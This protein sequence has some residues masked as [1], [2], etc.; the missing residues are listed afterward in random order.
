[1]KILYLHLLWFLISVNSLHAN[2][3][4]NEIKNDM[5]HEIIDVRNKYLSIKN[6]LLS[7]FNSVNTS[8][9][10]CLDSLKALSYHLEIKRQEMFLLIKEINLSHDDICSIDQLNNNSILLHNIINSFGGVYHSYLLH[11]NPLFSFDQYIGGME[12]LFKLEKKYP[13]LNDN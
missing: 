9:D 1:M 8:Y 6:E 4:I 10:Y 12:E 3:D 7:P 11:I 5:F 2:I 13:I